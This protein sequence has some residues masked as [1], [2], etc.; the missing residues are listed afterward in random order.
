MPA[1]GSNIVYTNANDVLTV[2]SPIWAKFNL[3]WIGL[4]L[5]FILIFFAKGEGRKPVPYIFNFIGTAFLIG[6]TSSHGKIV[7]DGVHRTVQMTT[8]VFYRSQVQKYSLD[9]IQGAAVVTS[10]QADALRLV[11]T[12][13]QQVQ[14]TPYNQMGGKDTAAHAINAFLQDHG[15][16]GSPY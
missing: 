15:Q 14:L 11:L 16:P 2:I 13:G 9:E 5:F 7:F 1:F 3:V 10:E 12:G 6:L 8:S 4:S